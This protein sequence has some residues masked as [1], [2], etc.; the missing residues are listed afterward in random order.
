MTP[1]VALVEQNAFI[2]IHI[3]FNLIEKDPVWKYKFAGVFV[4]TVAVLGST[5]N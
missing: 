2:E 4:V 5:R 1:C 3:K